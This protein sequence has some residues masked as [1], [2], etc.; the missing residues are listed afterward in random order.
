METVTLARAEEAV[1]AN[2]LKAFGQDMLQEA[3]D[4]LLGG[5]GAGFPVAGGAVTVAKGD[6]A[7]L[8]FEDTVVGESDPE[9]IRGQI[10]EGGL[11]RADR[12]TMDDPVLSPDRG[13]NLV[14]QI[15]LAKAARNL[16]RKRRERGLTWTKKALRARRQACPS[17]DRPP[18]GTR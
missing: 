12:L 8:E 1:I 14:D 11:A 9:D 3:A 17:A 18:P 6:L 5:E 2:L 7:L 16:A 15:S 10:L 4:E 13:G